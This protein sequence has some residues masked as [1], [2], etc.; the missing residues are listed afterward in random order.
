MI[1]PMTDAFTEEGARALAKKIREYWKACGSIVTTTVESGS[2]GDGRFW[3]VRSDM[4]NAMPR[5][6]V[7]A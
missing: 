5:Q 7:P 6:R 2:V 1:H 4:V 3:V